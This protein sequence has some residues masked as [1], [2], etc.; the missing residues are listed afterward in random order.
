MKH[1]GGFQKIF[2][3]NYVD[4]P[5]DGQMI[6]LKERAE[7]YEQVREAAGTIFGN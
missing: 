4:D 1:L 7:V 5:E 3:V 2:P 6:I